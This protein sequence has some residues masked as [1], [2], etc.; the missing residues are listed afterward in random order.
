MLILL[1]GGLRLPAQQ[2]WT[3]CIGERIKIVFP[4]GGA[5][6]VL[7]GQSILTHS[8]SGASISDNLGNLLF[9]A[10][11][12]S[13]V[14]ASNHLMPNGRFNN[15]FNSITVTQGLFILPT[16]GN[17][18]QY[19]VFHLAWPNNSQ[20]GGSIQDTLFLKHTK[21]DMALNGTLGGVILPKEVPVNRGHPLVE[22]IAAVKHA[23]G[24]D[25]WLVVHERD[26]NAFLV[27]LLNEQGLQAPSKQY[28]GSNHT[29]SLI[30]NASI[31]EMCF[32]PDGKRLLVACG[33]G[34][35]DLFD[36]DR[37]S[38]TLANWVLAANNPSEEF[39]GCS[40]SPDGSKY[41]VSTLDKFWHYDINNVGT[42]LYNN[43]SGIGPNFSQHELGPD[44]KIYIAGDGST[45]WADSLHIISNPNGSSVTCDFLST[46]ISCGARV[47]HNLPNFPNYNLGA[48]MAQTA[49]IGP[50]QEFLCQGDSLL[51]GY[52]DT[53][54]GSVTF[55]WRG[56]AL[57]DTTQPQQWVHPTASAWYYLTVIDSAFGL[58]CGITKDSIHVIVSNGSNVPVA[59]AGSDTTI[60]AG[61]GVTLD[62]ATNSN[63]SYQWDTGSDSATTIVSAAGTY[64]L[65]VKQIGASGA[66]WADTDFVV[67]DTFS[68]LAVLPNLAG[69]DQLVC[70]GDSVSLGVNSG[71][72]Y[73]YLWSPGVSPI[74]S[75]PSWAFL[76]GNYV[77]TILNPDSLGGCL[78]GTD[79]VW[80]EVVASGQLPVASLGA[81]T[82]ICFAD[83][84]SL[85]VSAVSGW[86]YAWSTGD[87]TSSVSVSASGSYSV[88]VTNPAAN[89]HC[90][91]DSDTIMITN[92]LIPQPL[93]LGFAGA[94]TIVCVG[95]SVLIGSNAVLG[96]NYVWSP[97]SSLN[98]TTVSQPIAFPIV[99]EQYAVAASDS[100]SG[101]VC[102]SVLDSVSI[103][104]EQ[105]F[106]H[107]APEDVTFCIGEC[108]V[109][110][111]NAVNGLQYS[112]SPTT[113]LSSPNLSLTKAQPT[114]TTTYFLTV[115]NPAL[116]TANC[117]ERIFPVVATADACNHQS[118]IAVNG[119]GV[120]ELL[121][122]G[123]HA[124]KVS[125]RVFDVAG[126]VVYGSDDYSNDPIGIGWNAAT[127]AKGLYVY[128]VNVGGD[129]PS[130]YVGKIIVLR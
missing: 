47:G 122:L 35:I 104:V 130:E 49:Q 50:P 94:D 123:D 125:F 16:I 15:N 118:F 73:S 34:F 36:F 20:A 43:T 6:N 97:G 39:Y 111:V 80:V 120:A 29:G 83:S 41:Y 30:F 24:Q 113:G 92:F 65:I 56:P 129:C 114:A 37:C 58:P 40:F 25:W 102:V 103:T 98:S 89:L 10:N 42:L 64:S 77:L 100:A 70:G 11:H 106:A 62:A 61:I 46:A 59:D 72:L 90:L 27:Y 45:P 2:D 93:Q 109:I 48:M 121:D 1:C 8:E 32:S 96:W 107:A 17:P 9:Y 52:P 28:I 60:C 21:I 53:T 84:V 4:F 81:D 79:T 63:W 95:E 105:P 126:R 86:L 110:G 51:L 54:S 26:S 22:K 76:Q 68:M 7:A 5:P 57:A 13:I 67:V 12:D 74:D 31:G 88:T 66:C 99:S 38:G 23:N 3:W 14:D 119:D 19:D 82:T 85:S 112:W 108:F 91:V 87:T 55:E 44:G 128:R 71:M 127:L 115:A 75:L 78:L 33:A 124:G 18:F 101:G 116:Q 117:R 69:P